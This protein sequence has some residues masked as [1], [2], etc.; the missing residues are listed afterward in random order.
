MIELVSV[1]VVNFR[2]FSGGTFCPLGI[3]QGMTAVNGPNGMGKSSIATHAVLWALYGVTPDGVPVRALRRQGSEGEVRATVTFRHEGDTISITRSLRGRG[4]TTTAA[5]TLDGVEQTTVSTRTATAWITN[6][7]GLDAEAFLT[8]FVV[9]QKELDSLVRAR[10]AERRKRIE[11]LAGI[12]RMSKALDIARTDAR[13]ALRL[14]QALPP[15]ED[16]SVAQRAVTEAQAALGEATRLSEAAAEAAQEAAYAYSVADKSLAEGRELFDKVQKATH[17]RD[18]AA[19]Q[20]EVTLSEVARLTKAAEG[21]ESLSAVREAAQRAREALTKAQ[22]A[23]RDLGGVTAR[24]EADRARANE[25]ATKAHRAQ[26]DATASREACD[27]A[28]ATLN[29]FPEDLPDRVTAATKKTSD[30]RLE[31]GAT[32][33]ELRRLENSIKGFSALRHEEANCPT[34]SRHVEDLPALVETLT[35]IRDE[36]AAKSAALKTELDTA[37]AEANELQAQTSDYTKVRER[38]KAAKAAAESAE[39]LA[40]EASDTAERLTAIAVASEQE[41]TLAQKDAATAQGSLPDLVE[42][43]AEAQSRLRRVETAAQA[44]TELPTARHTLDARQSALEEAETALTKATVSVAGLDL[45]EL[46]EAARDAAQTARTTSE[47]ATLTQAQHALATRD[48]DDANA[49]VARAEQ[50]QETRRNALA[51]VEKTQALASSLEEFRR[52]RLSR[53]APELSEVASDFVARMTDGRYTS[54]ELDEEFTAVLTA[55]DGTERPVAWLSGG[56]ESAVALALRIAIGEVL[57]GQRGGLL[58]LDEVLTAQDRNRRQATMAAI[59]ALPRQVVTINHVSEA[60]DMV[61]LVFEVIDDGEGASTL[62]EA[63]PQDALGA[64]LSEALAD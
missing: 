19:Q 40:S 13:A 17:F 10:P 30:L 7:L 46:E 48:L 36:V 39:L 44:A 54:V 25:A 61:D 62:M 8:A 47:K 55:A 9:R 64:D 12:E 33:G 15:V 11:R 18:L 51:D 49:T 27:H 2:S 50:A 41:A 52:D 43:E 16:P 35:K 21:A 42:A 57:A 45:L 14:L 37:E 59:R 23:V 20:V 32:E 22:Q 63:V 31:F 28:A 5:I 53:L 24:A 60:T 58:I 3:G 26:E 29:R 4:D 6:R 34:C 38:H 56:E 1:E